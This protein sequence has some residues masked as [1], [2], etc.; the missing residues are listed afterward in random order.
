[1]GNEKDG[2]DWKEPVA[3]A[4]YEDGAKETVKAIGATMGSLTRLILSPIKALADG[5]N[6]IV[7]RVVSRVAAR[8]SGIPP[9]RLRSPPAHVAGP[10]L[11]QLALIDE[12]ADELR[13]M[14]ENLLLRS[15]DSATAS[16]VHPAFSSMISQLTQN[17]AWILK[18]LDVEDHAAFEGVSSTEGERVMGMM[19]LLGFE[20]VPDDEA[21][22]E[23]ISNLI[24]LGIMHVTDETIYL[25]QELERLSRYVD[26]KATERA[27][28]RVPRFD[29]VATGR[30]LQVTALGKRFLQTCVHAPK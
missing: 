1:M 2:S 11:L 8:A 21:R 6:A 12:T 24:R 18:S 4:A 15:M 3:L 16:T 13:E 7:E 26:R 10:A 23:S 17:D 5:G 19:T 30:A 28:E 25:H 20:V 29:T 27:G 22:A 14:F 9:E